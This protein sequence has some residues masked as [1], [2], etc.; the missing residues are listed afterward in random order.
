[1][2]PKRPLFHCPKRRNFAEILAFATLRPMRHC[3]L[4]SLGGGLSRI[5]TQQF[6]PWDFCISPQ[7][8]S[9]Q[10][11][12]RVPTEFSANSQRISSHIDAL[13]GLWGSTELVASV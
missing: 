5:I 13:T 2:T 10:I 9:I 6:Q 12:P 7:K 4:A 11:T 8:E 1:M 3:P